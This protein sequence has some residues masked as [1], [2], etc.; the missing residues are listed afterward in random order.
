MLT[1]WRRFEF[2]GIPVYICPGRPDWFVPNAA[3]DRV[4]RESSFSPLPTGSTER[5][6]LGR[7]AGSPP[8]PYPGRSF[9]L[10]LEQLKELWFHV[11]NRCDLACGHCLFAS[12]PQ[13]DET[14]P[15]VRIAELATEAHRLG[16]RLFAL[17]G[18]EPTIHPEID[19][20]LS[21]LLD[22]PQ[23]RVA[24]LTNGLHL[25]RVAAA[26]AANPGRL[27]LQIS[28]DGLPET[29]DAVRGLGSFQRLHENLLALR[30]RDIPFTLSLCVTRANVAELAA[31]V[32]LAADLGAGNVHFM[33]YFRGGRGQEVG[34]VGAEEI[35][36]FLCQALRRAAA[37][38]LTIDNIEALKTQVFAPAG[39]IHDGSGAAWESLA[40]GPDDRLYPSA[41]LVGVKSMASGLAQGLEQ[42]WRRSPLLERIRRASAAGL[43][44]PFR[45]LLGGGD[46]D[47]SFIHAGTFVGDDPYLP[48]YEKMALHLIVDEARRQ[49]EQ[50]RPQL[51][52]RMGEILESCGAHGGVAL[53]H[54]NCLLGA[55]AGGSLKTVKSFYAE[56]VGDKKQE[57]LNPVCYPEELIRHIPAPFRFRGYGCGS[58]VLDGRILPG[59]TVVDLGCGGGVECFIAA[60]MAGATGHIIGV[61]ML[62]PMLALARTGQEGVAANLGFDNVDFRKGYLE[63]LPIADETADVV[64][65]NCVMNLS[66]HK[67]RAYREVFRILRH[68]GRLVISDVVCETEPAAALRN[69]ETLR[70][71]CIAGAMTQGHLA[72]LL[73]ETGFIGLHLIKRFPYRT[74]AGHP[75]FALTYRVFKPQPAEPVRAIYRGPLPAVE[76]ADGTLLA[77]GI[78]GLVSGHTAELLG[79]SLFVLDDDGRVTNIEVEN[80][81]ACCLPPENT[82]DNRP[83]AAALSRHRAQCMV[84]GSPLSYLATE[85]ELLCV[86]CQQ[87]FPAFSCCEK[88]HYVCDACHGADAL[89][90]IRKICLHSSETDLLRLYA[91]IRHH[92]AFPINGPEHHAL[93]PAV[94]LTVFRNRGG[95][96]SEQ[97]IEAA[98]RRGAAVPGG[99]CAY[100]GACGAALGVGIAFS[101]ILDANPLKAVER[102][103]VQLA[104]A[105]VLGAIAALKAPRCCQRD[106]WVALR[107]AALLSP[108]LL[109]VALSAEAVIDCCQR[110]ENQECSAPECPL[111][112]V[113]R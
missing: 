46:L 31:V 51:R 22:L 17:T 21:G 61:D 20:I 47:H 64:L 79:E 63:D 50:A 87:P 8:P 14:L 2:D 40:V 52:L 60:R 86:Y 4:L 26:A 99:C 66:V 54:A 69:D 32:D 43:D 103:Q 83:A 111:F 104:V 39:T 76:T 16:C 35:Y 62:D 107:K 6:F 93:V 11:T 97:L 77:T 90:V 36:P 53:V 58:P 56:A 110:R 78:P 91:E 80:G 49:P 18:G 12:S 68:G 34:F 94:I 7:F 108:R 48:L 98:M 5:R 109:P 65:S 82:G 84:C 15:A 23:S 29:H 72:A 106:C 57:I 24:V 71:E 95:A 44:S 42:A 101:L 81:C 105:E 30:K 3:G 73:E 70:G 113:S 102:Q 45:F 67:R 75:F 92:P 38:G 96:V 112:Q 41:A 33:W 28:V 74:V 13:R 27:F 55:A 85:A 25:H 1:H 37:R 9:L 59:E 89:E 88:G 100:L 19:T 10:K